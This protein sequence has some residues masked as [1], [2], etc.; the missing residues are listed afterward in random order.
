MLCASCAT[1]PQTAALTPGSHYVALGS[2]YAA[3]ANIPPLA[4]DRPQ[5][6]GA[7]Q[8]S[9]ARLLAAR[10]ALDLTDASCGGAT[11]EHLLAAWD[12]LPAQIDALRADTRLVTVTVGGND[13][14]YM[15]LMFTAS[16][17]AGVGNP[18]TPE[19][20]AEQCPPLPVP[21]EADYAAVEDRLALLFA[22]IRRRAPSA[23]VVLVQYV[24]LADETACDAAPLLP[25][26]ATITREV[27]RRLALASSRAAQRG[28]AEVLP[29][30]V[31]SRDHTPCSPDPWSRGHHAEYDGT[32]GAPWHP[33]AAGHAAIADELAALLGA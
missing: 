5:R 16:C 24:A 21:A 29:V 11:T 13:L 19:G 33:T 1:L 28:G 17:H 23:R 2:S 18:R 22:A 8:V 15:G 10:L 14:N 20:S 32:Q 4:N 26:Q 30:D 7:S 31:L 3:G 12:E 6:C 9:Y 25:E 27:A